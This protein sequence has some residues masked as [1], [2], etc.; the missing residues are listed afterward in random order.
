VESFLE[1]DIDY[2]MN[3]FNGINLV[4]T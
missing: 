1:N 2:A 3:A 4:E